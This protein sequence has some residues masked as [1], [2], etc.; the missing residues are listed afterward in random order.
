MDI[1]CSIVTEEAYEVPNMAVHWSDF[2]LEFNLSEF[3]FWEL[4]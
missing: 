1:W 3:L 2:K 4:V